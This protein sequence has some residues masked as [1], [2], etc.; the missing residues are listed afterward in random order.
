MERLDTTLI[1]PQAQ[2]HETPIQVPRGPQSD[3]AFIESNVAPSDGKTADGGHLH[4]PSIA[5]MRR[6][7]EA[8]PDPG[9]FRGA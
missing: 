9:H 5:V 8:H 2:V 4:S 1:A 7:V 3:S 6:Q